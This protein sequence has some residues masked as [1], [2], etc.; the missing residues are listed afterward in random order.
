MTTDNKKSVK[1]AE[2]V[3]GARLSTSFH[4]V[5]IPARQRWNRATLRTTVVV[6]MLGIGLALSVFNNY[7]FFKELL[8]A[9][10]ITGMAMLL[11]TAR[12]PAI[13]IS[14]DDDDRAHLN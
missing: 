11:K 5:K 14:K 13:I 10:A 9:T 3:A 2:A 1:G 7:L 6:S 4:E 12:H 8:V